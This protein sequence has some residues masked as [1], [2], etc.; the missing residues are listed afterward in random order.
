MLSSIIKDLPADTTLEKVR[1]I[2]DQACAKFEKQ[3]NAQLARLKNY[4]EANHEELLQKQQEYRELN[5]DKLNQKNREYRESNREKLREKNR[6]YYI[7]KTSGGKKS[8]LAEIK[9]PPSI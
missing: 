9:S 6:E 5:R 2:L 4:R 8:L 7:R 1:D 3:R